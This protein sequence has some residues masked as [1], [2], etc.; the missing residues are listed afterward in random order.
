M[1]KRFVVAI[2]GP[3]GGVERHSMKEWLRSHPQELPSGMVAQGHNSHSLRDA[4]KKQGWSVNETEDEALLIRPEVARDSSSIAAL[5][6][7]ADEE[8]LDVADEFEFGLESHLRD[9]IARNIGTIPI[10]NHRLKLYL[11]E[12][13]SGIEFSTDVGPIDILAV[14]DEGN[15][16]VFELKLARGPDRAM[17]QLLR[18]MG[19]VRKHLANGKQ[20]YGVIVAKYVDQELRY[21][22]LPV[23][24]VSVLE[25][26]VDFRLRPAA[27]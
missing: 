21:A 7:P 20:V 12:E 17:G 15:L 18:Y 5:G 19:W 2:K 1:Y 8:V 16:F 9:F 10:T 11:H 23:P 3:T 25:Y 22:A 27:L 14:D 4:L 13:C 6:E 24:N 26:E